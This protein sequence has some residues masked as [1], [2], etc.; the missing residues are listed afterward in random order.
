MRIAKSGAKTLT[1]REDAF[2]SSRQAARVNGMIVTETHMWQRHGA[3]ALYAKPQKR[4]THRD[5][6]KAGVPE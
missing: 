6:V 1:A 3:S 2:A 4:S 5:T